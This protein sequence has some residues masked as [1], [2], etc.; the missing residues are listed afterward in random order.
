MVF[1]KNVFYVSAAIA[2]LGLL[3]FFRASTVVKKTGEISAGIMKPVAKS[4][5]NLRNFL[6]YDRE[7]EGLL[8]KFNLLRAEN[9]ELET[10]REENNALRGLLGFKNEKKISLI[11]GE[12]VHYGQELGREFLVAEKGSSDGVRKGDLAIDDNGFFVGLVKET[13]ANFSKIE[14]ASVPGE[15]FEVGIVSLGIKALAKGLGNRTFSLELLP[16]SAEIKPGDFVELIGI[17]GNR[18]SFLLGEIK[19]VDSAGGSAFKNARMI[20]AAQPEKLKRIFFLP[21][22]DFAK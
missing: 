9:F 12:V 20:M 14:I 17:A 7:N 6:S 2:L 19:D 10:L 4:A 18:Y 5:R 8:E 11:G 22:I 15:T 13:Y 21:Q 16:S 3:L 1:K